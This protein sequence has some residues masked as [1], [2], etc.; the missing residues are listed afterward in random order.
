MNGVCDE[1]EDFVDT[2]G[3]GV[4]DEG[5]AFTDALNGAYDEGEDV[6]EGNGVY[7]KVKH[8]Q[9]NPMDLMI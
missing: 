3:N 5:E 7:M 8:S 6:D 9:M 2:I 4:Y 1:G